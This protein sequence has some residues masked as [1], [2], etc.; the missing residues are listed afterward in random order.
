MPAQRPRRDQR[1]GRAPQRRARIR[2]RWGG[3]GQR[4]GR[5]RRAGRRIVDHLRLIVAVPLVAVVGFAGLA[6][7]TTAQEA[8]RTGHLYELAALATNAGAVSHALQDER[9]VAAQVL[10]SNSVTQLDVYTKT[11][12]ATDQAVRGYRSRRANLSDDQVGAPGLL[13]RIDDAFN[14]LADLRKQVR[15]SAQASVS[16]VAFSYR[17]V[18]VDLIDLRD[19][20]IR[21]GAPTDISDHVRAAAALS[22]AVEA[23]GQQQIAGLRANGP[24]RLTPALRLELAAART[25][26]ADAMA[27]FAALASPDW[28][29]WY[30]RASVGDAILTA[31]RLQDEVA[32]AQLG[33]VQVDADGWMTAMSGWAARLS[34]LQQRV[35]RAVSD[36]VARLRDQQE[37]QAGIEAGGVAVI[38]VLAVVLTSVVA[39]RITSRLERLHDAARMVAYERLPAVVAELRA[40]PP[41]TVRPDEVA[42]RSAAEVAVGGSDEIAEVAQAFRSVHREAVRIAGEQAVMRSNVAEIFVHLSRREQRLVDA[43]LA[44][45]DRV[46]RDETDPDR[47][48]QLYQLDHLATR[49]A[50]INLSLLVLGGSSA[51]RVRH[52]DAPLAKVLQAAISQIEHYTRVSFGLVDDDVVVVAAAV[53]EIVHLLAELLDNATSYSPSTSEVWV[54][55]RALGDRI[56]IQIGDN[57]TGLSQERREQLNRLLSAPPA[58]DIAMVRAMGLTV[59]GHIAARYDIHVELRQTRGAGTTAEI[60]LPSKV[61]RPLAGDRRAVLAPPARAELPVIGVNAPRLGATPG[62]WPPHSELA[63][64]ADAALGRAPGGSAALVESADNGAEPPIFQEVSGWFRTERPT[65]DGTAVNWE[66]AA[67]A[68][69]LAAAQAAT[70]EI[71]E[72]TASGLP[73]R[74]PQRHLVPGAAAPPEPVAEPPKRDPTVIAAVMSAYARGV[75]ARRTP[76][77]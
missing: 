71:S 77:E 20:V 44:Q 72:R 30:E 41:G 64:S 18:I 66:S 70:P 32:R 43:V 1:S 21:A 48:Q 33:G 49:M 24:G 23:I 3:V 8:S 51:S 27:S 57:G 68:G 37:S 16:A 75:A 69:W 28:R 39:R 5:E 12:A 47:L 60:T 7:F 34:D 59:V 56:I 2:V 58:I 15:T 52:E 35:D 50:R 53:D 17:I 29:T 45:V 13:G 11:V 76:A 62:A 38:L 42:N 46:E 54:T 74:Q 40:A 36:E 61:F 73:V 6:L 9:A 14:G 55:G 67:D 25:G 26:I 63:A 4:H 22:R 10:A 65:A 31:Q 19:A